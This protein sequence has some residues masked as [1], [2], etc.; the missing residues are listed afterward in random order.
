MEL[1]A[2]IDDLAALRCILAHLELPEARDSSARA[3]CVSTAR[4]M[5]SQ[6]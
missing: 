3:H 5:L 2:T 1:I 4:A 6:P